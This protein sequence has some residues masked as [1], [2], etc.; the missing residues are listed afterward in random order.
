MY[1]NITYQQLKELT[2]EQK[3]EAI[4]SLKN[5]YATY[6]EMAQAVGGVP[7]ALSN[8]YLRLVDGKKM[9]RKKKDE[10]TVQPKKNSVQ[11][12]Q[13]EQTEKQSEPVLSSKELSIKK[14]KSASDSSTEN[15][16]TSQLPAERK[17]ES[18]PTTKPKKS[19]SFTIG[20]E[21]EA[22]GEE[23]KNRIQG[24]ANSLLNN[25]TYKIKVIVEEV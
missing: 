10:T 5:K 1:E 21:I 13:N 7:V 2:D 23:A 16:A 24:V 14:Q 6:K 4:I 12:N 17:Q 3:K 20:M 9:G 15:V 22:I 25:K 11:D 19:A 18:I 8:L